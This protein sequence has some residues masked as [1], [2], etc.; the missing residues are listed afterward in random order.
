[1]TELKTCNGEGGGGME[2]SQRKQAAIWSNSHIRL[3]SQTRLSP[4]GYEAGEGV[5]W[6]SWGGECISVMC[7]CV[8]MHVE[9]SSMS[10]P[11]L[12]PSPRPNQTDSQSARLS[13]PWRHPWKGPGLRQQSTGVCG[14]GE[15]NA[16]ESHC[17]DLQ[18]SCCSSCSVLLRGPK[19]D[20]IG[21]DWGI[22]WTTHRYPTSPYEIN[23]SFFQVE[24]TRGQ[25]LNIQGYS[26]KWSVLWEKNNMH[27]VHKPL[28]KLSLKTH[29]MILMASEDKAWKEDQHPKKA[30]TR[31]I[32][33]VSKVHKCSLPD[34]GNSWNV[35]ECL[36]T[37]TFLITPSD[38]YTHIPAH[39]CKWLSYRTWRNLLTDG[40]L[41]WWNFVRQD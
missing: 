17:S 5:G 20:K 22:T 13:L 10:R 1:M 23:T 16:R 31:K 19:A 36:L 7:M 26:S 12:S 18:G 35:F 21:V 41:Y 2:V 29:K 8:C 33:Q 15:G 24:N 40:A 25:A 27:K 3:W 4:W 6:G 38:Y 11:G 37:C 14:K 9:S 28:I 30:E 32:Y 39:K 34:E